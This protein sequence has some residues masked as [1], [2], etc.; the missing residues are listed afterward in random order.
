[1]SRTPTSTGLHKKHRHLNTKQPVTACSCD[2]TA[3]PPHLLV[4]LQGCQVAR[5]MHIKQLRTQLLRLAQRQG[6][7]CSRATSAAAAALLQG[8]RAGCCC[9]L[10]GKRQHNIG[11]LP[12]VQVT[13]GLAGLEG[14]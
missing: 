10:G 13:P 5:D 11:L 4:K 2:G 7:R 9:C 1:M 14:V 12:H 8:C 3:R 6:P